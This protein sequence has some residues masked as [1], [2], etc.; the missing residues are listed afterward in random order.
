MHA[1][2]QI[3]EPGRGAFGVE[4]LDARVIVG[5]GDDGAGDG[6]PVLG[7]GILE[8]DL[9]SLVVGEVAEFGGVGVG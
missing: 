6:G 3:A 1:V 8:G 2:A 9:G 7:G 5:G 4:V